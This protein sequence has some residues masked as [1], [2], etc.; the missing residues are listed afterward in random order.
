MKFIAVYITYAACS[1]V[2]YHSKLGQ[3]CFLGS[4]LFFYFQFLEENVRIK[5]TLCVTA[6]FHKNF[7]YFFFRNPHTFFS[8]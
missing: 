3:I 8:C 6:K 2:L 4:D 7:I 1:T 5:G